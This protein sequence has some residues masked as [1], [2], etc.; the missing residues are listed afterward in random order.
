MLNHG[1]TDCKTIG[2][3]AVFVPQSKGE[4]HES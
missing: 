1:V 3:K 2:Q 4:P